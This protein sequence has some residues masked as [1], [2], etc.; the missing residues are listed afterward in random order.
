MVA[1]IPRGMI[2]F[3]RYL[4][5]QCNNSLSKGLPRKWPIPGVKNVI[6]VSS[7]K[8]GV[9]K[10]TTAG[11]HTLCYNNYLCVGVLFFMFFGHYFFP[12]ESCTWYGNCK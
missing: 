5:T 12:S 11:D 3:G 9:G 6:M 7:G 8:G 1:G 2:A 10:S 4:S